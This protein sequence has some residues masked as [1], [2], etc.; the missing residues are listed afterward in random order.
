MRTCLLLLAVLLSG[1]GVATGPKFSGLEDPQSDEA[2][3]YVFRHTEGLCVNCAL[4]Y[5]C[6]FIN[7]E[8]K[9]PLKVGGYLTYR[10]APEATEVRVAECGLLSPGG[11]FQS[12]TVVIDALPAMRY[13]IKCC[14][15]PIAGPFFSTVSE[16][17]ALPELRQLKRTN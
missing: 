1:C 11:M 4:E 12:K 10:I 6:V 8:K 15:P 7:D 16:E 13:Y 17:A 9:D 2:I 14:S 5:P 3:L